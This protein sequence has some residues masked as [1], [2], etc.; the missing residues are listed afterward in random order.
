MKNM[1][2]KM[3]QKGFTLVELMIVVAIIGILSAVAVPNFKKYQAKSKSSEAKIQLAAAYTAEQSFYGDFGMYASCLNYM[4]YNPS[5]E[6]DARYYSIGFGDPTAIDTEM[7]TTAR[8]SGLA[9]GTGACTID[10]T[11]ADSVTYFSAGKG[12]GGVVSSTVEGADSAVGAQ[13]AANQTF[14]CLL[15]TSPSPRD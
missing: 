3:G 5:G 11:A 9:V 15:Y 13:T 6:K 8:R 2:K 1:V 12:S 14:T 4:G 7:A 10:T